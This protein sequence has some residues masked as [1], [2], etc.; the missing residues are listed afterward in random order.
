MQ[1]K[2]LGGRKALWIVLYLCQD[3]SQMLTERDFPHAGGN[4]I[5]LSLFV[6][7]YLVDQSILSNVFDNE[8]S[9]SKDFKK[10]E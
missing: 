8:F 9:P 2:A 10:R 4:K 7:E 3:S 5:V 1:K 6:L